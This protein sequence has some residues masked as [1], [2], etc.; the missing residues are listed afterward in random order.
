MFKAVFVKLWLAIALWGAFV[1]QTFAE[2]STEDIFPEE[3]WSRYEQMEQAGFIP[4]RLNRVRKFYDR[5]RFAG[6]LVVKNGAVVVDWGE[7]DRRFLVHSIRK[8]MLSTLYGIHYSNID[9]TASLAELNVT[10][11]E[12]LT[13]SELSATLSDI[14]AS[15]SGIYLPAAAEGGQMISS[16]PERGSHLPGT[17]WW[18]NNWDF[19]VAGSIFTQLTNEEI[20]EA[21]KRHIAEPIQMQDFREFDSYSVSGDSEHQAVQFRMSSRD[22]ARLGLLYER[23]GNWQGHQLI[24]SEWVSKSTQAM[25]ETNMGDK[26]PPFYGYMWWVEEDGSYSARGAGGHIL[27]VYPERDLVIVLRVNT[28]LEHSVSAKAIK[29]ILEGIISASEGE[30]SL[31]PELTQYE[32]N[33]AAKD[34]LPIWYQDKT[35]ALSLSDGQ[36]VTLQSTGSAMFVNLGSGELELS[37]EKENQFTIID[38]KEPLEITLGDNGEVTALRTPRLFYLYAADAAQNGE[39]NEAL[40]WVKEVIAMQPDSAMAYTNMAKIYIAQNDIKNAK[41][42]LDE[43]LHFD[44]KNKQANALTQTLFVKQW[45]L[46]VVFTIGLAIFLFAFLIVKKRKNKK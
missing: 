17:H 43:A 23:N 25:S 30:V 46:P 33:Q 16:R 10:E 32:E 26:Y 29:K 24:P 40:Q 38:R 12:L 34:N 5:K 6:L 3:V 35:F 13:A 37:Y 42:M 31:S 15:R 22:L 39:L 4:H 18:Y 21:F 20:A 44:P 36:I 9:L 11:G 7:N 14:L 27:A 8:S 2:N 41:I 45:L 19:N 28:Y 1:C